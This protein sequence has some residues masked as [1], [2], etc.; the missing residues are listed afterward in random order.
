MAPSVL[1]PCSAPSAPQQYVTCFPE[2]GY[3]TVAHVALVEVATTSAFG[4]SGGV[5]ASP[6]ASPPPASLGAPPSAGSPEDEDDVVVPE[7]EDEED[8]DDKA[9]LSGASLVS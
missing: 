9:P 6:S 4:C 2:V 8:E 5:A 7:E 3:C 1:T